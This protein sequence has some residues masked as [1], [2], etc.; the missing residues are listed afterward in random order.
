MYLRYLFFGSNFTKMSISRKCQNLGVG[1]P[2]D[3]TLCLTKILFYGVFPHFL[4][5]TAAKIFQRVLRVAHQNQ[6]TSETFWALHDG[7]I[8]FRLLVKVSIY[9][10][11]AKICLGQSVSYCQLL[12]HN[13]WAIQKAWEPTPKAALLPNLEK[14]PQVDNILT[15]LLFFAFFIQFSPTRGFVP[16]LV[17]LLER[18]FS[19]PTGHI[20]FYNIYFQN[21]L[22]G[23]RRFLGG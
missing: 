16:D 3:I 19:I 17:G 10:G 8:C 23:D 14:M 7:A 6:A 22:V 21:Q 20:L 4:N 13:V 15:E 18:C 9:M 1:Y 11:V 12:Q 5:K 2:G